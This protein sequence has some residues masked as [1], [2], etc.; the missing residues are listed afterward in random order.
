MIDQENN[1][2]KKLI[3]CLIA[4]WLAGCETKVETVD[5]IV[6]VPVPDPTG[7]PLLIDVQ[8]SG[9]D[10]A[11]TLGGGSFPGAFNEV[12]LLAFH[13]PVAQSLVEVGKSNDGSYSAM[14]VNGTY[15]TT[16]RFDMGSQIP[17]NHFA[18]VQA[19]VAVASTMTVDM[20]VPVVSVRPQFL[21]NGGSFPASQYDRARFF[22]V[23][24]AGGEPIFLGESHVVNDTVSI[25]PGAYHV[26]YSQVQGGTVPVNQ[27]AR[28]MSDVD[29][30]GD[31]QLLVDVNAVEVRTAFQHNGGPFPQSQYERAEFYLVNDAGDEAFLGQSYFAPATV[32]V[33]GG[34][35]DLEYRHQQGSTVPLNK[36]TRVRSA[37]DLTAGGDASVDVQSFTLDINATLNGQ[38]FPVSEYD[39]G[40]L[41]LLDTAS[42]SYSL[43]G[44]THSPFAGLVVIAGSYDIVYSHETGNDVPQNV[45]GNVLSGYVVAGNQQLDLDITGHSMTLALTLDNGDFPMSPYDYAD[46]LLKGAATAG[47]I[48]AS[49]TIAQDEPFMVLPGTYDVTYACQVCTEVPFN[50]YAPII[51]DL[52]IAADGVIAADITSVRVKT[53]ATLN[54]AAFPQSYYQSGVIYGGLQEGDVVEL[55][56]TATT[57]DDVILIAGPYSFYYQ[58]ENGEQVPANLWSLV[59]QQAISP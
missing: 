46:I 13:D 17:A 40:E 49:S 25:V 14:L 20:D 52:E 39:D 58:H 30:S 29:I 2:Y 10:G 35:Y 12:G 21:L 5:N 3:V 42:G 51:D 50:S 43:L 45:R 6:Q 47:E 44:N 36:A 22:L 18:V 34:V 8:A 54:G 19:G 23:P 32:R 57:T 4:V 28:V 56:S 59:G 15:D 11:F 26:I 31:M 41:E 55:T 9:V 48:V 53:T 7:Q 38:P 16:Y 27:N 33:I 1:V 24:V 37:I